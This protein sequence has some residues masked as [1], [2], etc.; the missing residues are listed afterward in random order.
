MIVPRGTIININ[1]C[2][3]YPKTSTYWLSLAF[4][5]FTQYIVYN[6][7]FQYQLFHVEQRHIM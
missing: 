7:T 5:Q 2:S 4:V 3:Y 6:N 1:A